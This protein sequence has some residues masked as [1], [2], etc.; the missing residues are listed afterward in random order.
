LH[1]KIIDDFL[2]IVPG[3]V[4]GV[5]ALRNRRQAR[6]KSRSSTATHRAQKKRKE[7]FVDL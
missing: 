5:E 2:S 1:K 4:A 3:R 6:E 7:D